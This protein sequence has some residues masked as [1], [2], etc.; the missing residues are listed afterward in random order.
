MK[1]ARRIANL[2]QRTAASLRWSV[3]AKLI[4][5][6]ATFFTTILLARLLGAGDFGLVAVSLIYIGFLQMFVDA[7]FLPALIQ[8]AEINQLEMASCFWLLLFTGSCAIGCTLLL[9]G[10]LD[11][12][13]GIIGAGKV[14]AV[15]STIFLVMPFRTLAVAILSRDV[16]IDL[17]SKVEGAVNVA[18]LGV[19][20]LMALEG[21]GV[22][23]LVLPQ[24][25]GQIIFSL[26]CY[27]WA[28]WHPSLEFSWSA[29]KPLGGY[30]LTITLSQLVWFAGS[31]LDQLIIGKILGAEALGF[32]S[33]AMQLACAIPQ[34]ASA[35]V[36]RVVFPVFSNL[37]DQST[38]LKEA[39]L[40]TSKYISM[41]CMP[42]SAG[43]VLLAPSFFVVAFKPAWQPA[44]VPLQ[45]LC[46]LAFLRINEGIA[47]FL[48]NARGKPRV[49]VVFNCIA[50]G[51]LGL[52]L[53]TGFLLGGLSS[54]A[55]CI[56][57]S[58][59]PVPIL[60]AWAAIHEC[61]G[62]F[63]EYICSFKSSLT[64]TS[65]MAVAI[66]VTCHFLPWT[67]HVLRVVVLVPM[68]VLVYFGAVLYAEPGIVK[69]IA[70]HLRH[71]ESEKIFTPI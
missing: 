43:I 35:T 53:Y 37:Q 13:F 65:V 62:K 57:V 32:Y 34:F 30:G 70:T 60:T 54:V 20:L 25:T 58:F 12:F 24:V 44:V 51:L 56:A 1:T 39:F 31:R 28:G 47:G 3:A 45:W 40:T 33:L 55:L 59:A 5:Q 61:G 14:I 16:R 48:I 2:S 46:L 22:W 64:G 67:G 21:A 66:L 15:Q 11:G 4:S 69:E 27:F 63:Y 36:S 49:N 71:T 8:R 68:G 52:G 18:M 23:S 10:T 9:H 38:K 7:G 29:V 17:I 26:V 6:G 41:A 50:L 19:S 42:A